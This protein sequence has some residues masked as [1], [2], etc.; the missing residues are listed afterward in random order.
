M[1]WEQRVFNRYCIQALIHFLIC[2]V[3]DN[4]KTRRNIFKQQTRN[5]TFVGK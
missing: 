1:Y 5:V 3:Y 4:L 2:V